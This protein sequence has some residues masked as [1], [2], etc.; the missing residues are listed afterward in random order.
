MERLEWRDNEGEIIDVVLIEVKII[1]EQD[2][3]VVLRI[4]YEYFEYIRDNGRFNMNEDILVE[5]IYDFENSEPVVL[6]LKLEP[7]LCEQLIQDANDSDSI[8]DF[9]IKE[10]EESPDSFYFTDEVW[11]TVNVFQEESE[12]TDDEPIEEIISEDL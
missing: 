7:H 8:E 3:R 11:N 5:S 6:E 1:S 4:D 10:N 12:I 9:L 2:I